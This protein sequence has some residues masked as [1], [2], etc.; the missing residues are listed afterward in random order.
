VVSGSY[1]VTADS[2]DDADVFRPRLCELRTRSD[3]DGFGFDV[4]ANDEKDVKYVGQI[5]PGSPADDAG[6]C[7]ISPTL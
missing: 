4:H 7:G 5:E 3:F 6:K 1:T 2:D